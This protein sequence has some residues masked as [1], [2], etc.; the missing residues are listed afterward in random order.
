MTKIRLTSMFFNITS[1]SIFAMQL[2]HVGR[3]AIKGFWKW[4]KNSVTE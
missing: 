4:V 1:L 2:R 3:K